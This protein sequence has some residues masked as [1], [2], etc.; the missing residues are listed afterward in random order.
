MISDETLDEFAEYFGKNHYCWESDDEM[1]FELSINDLIQE[2]RVER[3]ARKRLE[4]GIRMIM[5][6]PRLSREESFLK[7]PYR[8]GEEALAEAKELVGEE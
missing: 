8:L 1:E 7:N 4:E 2:I 3:K 5:K 6:H